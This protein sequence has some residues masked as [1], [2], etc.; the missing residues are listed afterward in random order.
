[1]SISSWLLITMN[2]VPLIGALFFAWDV[3]VIIVLYWIENL[4]IG[5][6][7]ILKMSIVA[8]SQQEWKSFSMVAFFALHY[9]AFCAGHGNLLMEL[10]DM[11]NI[12]R[13]L[14]PE[15]EWPGPL[16]LAQEAWL[17]LQAIMDAL[18]AKLWLGVGALFLSRFVSF[19]EYFIFRAEYAKAKVKDLMTAPYR[20]LIVLHVGLIVGG[21]VYYA[22]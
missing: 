4:M 14:S 22:V 11:E 20:H 19:L 3:Q 21:Y 9:G 8:V 13:I 12:L 6:F 7:N 10:L 17:T 15:Q 5:V 18:G 16:V 1:M 2:I